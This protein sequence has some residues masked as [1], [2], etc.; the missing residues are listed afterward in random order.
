MFSSAVSGFERYAG[1]WVPGVVEGV[2][3]GR[4]TVRLCGFKTER[5]DKLSELVAVTAD[6]LTRPRLA[7]PSRE[8]KEGT[9]CGPFGSQKM[10][11]RWTRGGTQS[12]SGMEL[13]PR[14]K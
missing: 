10:R 8:W 4:F 3:G 7:E 9:T 6:R 14:A 12:L 13:T 11:T 2:D 1:A 5:S